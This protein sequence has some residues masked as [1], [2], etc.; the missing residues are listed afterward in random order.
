[1][2]N[3]SK[4]ASI[5]DE[6][7]SNES[8]TLLIPPEVKKAID[9]VIPSI[10]PLDDPDFNPTD[11]IN[12]LF[13][14]EQSLSNIDDVIAELECKFHGINNQIST[15][16]G[17]QTDLKK[18][19]RRAL[20]DAQLVIKQLFNQ[21]LEIKTKAEQSEETVKE[22]TREIKQLDC[23]KINLTASIT[24]INH[25]HFLVGGVNTLKMLAGKRQYGEIVMPLQGVVDVVKHF[26]KYTDIPQIKTLTDDVQEIKN[27]L[28]EQI[29]HDFHKA[30]T[31]IGA[32]KFTPT[33]SLAEA[34][35][36]IDILE[37]KVK[38][39][40]LKWFVTIQF[41]EYLVLFCD[42]EENAWLDKIDK[43]YTWFKKYL[44]QCED[45]FGSLFPPHWEVFEQITI[46]FCL[47][48]RAELT[49]IMHKRAKEIDVKLLLY[50]IQRTSIFEHLLSARFTEKILLEKKDRYIC[51]KINIEKTLKQ[52]SAPILV[53]IKNQEDNQ[54]I[55]FRE[56]EISEFQNIIGE[57]FLPYLYIYIDSIDLNL[58][59]LFERFV[60]E[61]K[62][63]FNNEQ[64]VRKTIQGVLPSSGD[65]FVFYKKFLVQCNQLSNGLPMLS[66]CEIFKKYLMEYAVKILQSNLPVFGGL[67]SVSMSSSVN[68]IA[69][70]FPSA[71]SIIQ[72]FLKEGEISRFSKADVGR[73]CCIVITSEYCLEMTRQLEEKVKE[74]IDPSL[75]EKINFTQEHDIFHSVI[76]NC[77]QLLVQDLEMACEPAL[78]A[79]SKIDWM[80]L[81]TVGDQSAYVTKITSHLKTSIPFIKDS[82]SS[83]RK[84]FTQ[85]C[86]RFANSIIS[87]FI[88][89]LFKCKPLSTVGAEQLLLDTH[90]LKTVLLDIP[91]LGSHVDMKAPAS[92]IKVILTGMTRGEMILKLVMAPI[93]PATVFVDQFLKLL[94]DFDIQEFQKVLDM[95]GL[96]GGEKNNLLSIFRLKNPSGLG[97]SP[98][99]DT[100]SSVW[101]LNNLI[102]KNVVVIN[103]E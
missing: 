87:K 33:R 32:S 34:C 63:D 58:Y 70:D 13:P 46:K 84:Y 83:S 37:P 15:V 76:S 100:S 6:E 24:T 61:S 96:K 36:V 95:K 51:S 102:K 94:P 2:T 78:S 64:P 7:F 42:S 79:M 9:K 68:G 93:E 38:Q 67:N 3:S 5:E 20:V 77:T 80:T 8:S 66:L 81:E 14:S 25:L 72:N 99:Q 55:S 98:K 97:T 40:F 86:V 59:D 91:S 19:G 11:Y 31:G 30:F 23:A 17:R 48:T 88:K 39:E 74:K 82:L 45:K 54:P 26:F 52:K 71:S 50:A 27:Y 18:D 90:M 69:R 73:I 49:K 92:Y 89:T 57:C 21:T 65:L 35:L 12:S 41:D 44:I 16:V 101:K 28:A 56:Q 62:Q 60:T 53:D 4:N 10:D 85:F 47:T 22:I 29:K 1:M 43:R 75:Y 103:G